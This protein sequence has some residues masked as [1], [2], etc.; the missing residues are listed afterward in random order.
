MIE[1]YMQVDLNNPLAV[2]YHEVALKSF[3]CVSDI[4]KINVVQ[5]I[6]PDT[7]LD[8]PFSD[9]KRRSPQEKASLCSQYRMHKR[10]ADG[11]NFFI[12]EHDAYLRPDQEGV[13][14]MIMSKWEQMITLN[15]GIAME[16]YTCRRQ[17]SSLFCEFV[18]N[19]QNTSTTGPMGI[20]HTA[21]DQWVKNN[22]LNVRAVYWPKLGKDN[23][24]GI[25]TNVTRAHRKPQVVI[26]A[27]VTQLID[28]NLGTTVTDRP[29]TQVKNIYN[30]DSHPN[31][32]F[33]DF[34]LDNEDNSLV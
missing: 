5:C 17:I 24:T 23:K 13:F 1:G 25:S 11:E 12:M 16:C 15:I 33:I 10:I 4:F 32:K 27:P 8:L 19:D 26:E 31:F 9:K 30:L 7:L 34:S 21:T 29:K 18:E 3:E 2:R 6:T 20:L 14:R 22:K 28:T